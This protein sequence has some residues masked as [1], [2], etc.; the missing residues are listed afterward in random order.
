MRLA[1]AVPE[2][3]AAQQKEK[4]M[5][6]AKLDEAG[7]ERYSPSLREGVLRV[8][9]RVMGPDDEIVFKDE[10]SQIFRYLNPLTGHEEPYAEPLTSKA[11]KVGMHSSLP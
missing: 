11:E 1:R 10:G 8:P 6:N 7:W 9:I 2:D 5:V 4:G 3:L